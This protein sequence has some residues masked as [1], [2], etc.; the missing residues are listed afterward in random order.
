MWLLVEK[1]LKKSLNLQ[2]LMWLLEEKIEKK[3]T[4]QNPMWLLDEK[5][6]KKLFCGYL[7][8]K[9]AFTILKYF[10]EHHRMA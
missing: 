8:K 3:L 4:L 7:L 5:V 10:S 6:E 9:F 2:N 1:E